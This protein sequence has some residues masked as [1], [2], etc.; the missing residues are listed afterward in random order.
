MII[1]FESGRLGNQLFQYSA[2]RKFQPRGRILAVGMSDLKAIFTGLKIID[3]K[4]IGKLLHWIIKTIGEKRIALLAKKMRLLT[5]VEELQMP[6][7]AL[8]EVHYGLIKN[9][10]YFKAG[11]YQSENIVDQEI[12][13]EISIKPEILEYSKQIHSTELCKNKNEYFVH[14]RRGDYIYWP[15]SDSPA[16]LP[17]SWYNAQID[18]IRKADSNAAFIV[19]SDDAPYAEEFF[20]DKSNIKVFHGELINE[21]VIMTQCFA[22][23]ILSASSFSWWAAYFCRVN[24]PNALFVAPLYWA[25]HRK[26]VWCP[27]CS[28]TSWINYV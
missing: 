23:G 22:G 18:R 8:F 26:K 1:F 24:N 9:V 12:V 13:K 21:F 28:E 19:V 4:N 14:I 15:S 25:G 20:C 7:K 6:N 3:N 17:L 27:I 11:Y 10:V 2:M 16:V 5:V